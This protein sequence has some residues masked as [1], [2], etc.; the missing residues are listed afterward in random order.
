MIT[1]IIDRGAKKN[2]KGKKNVV[3]ITNLEYSS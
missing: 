2:S 3:F 1:M